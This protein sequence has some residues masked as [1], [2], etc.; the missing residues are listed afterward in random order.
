MY[1]I[2]NM[3]IRSGFVSNSSSSSFVILGKYVDIDNISFDTIKTNDIYVLGH[4]LNEGRDIF[5]IKNEEELAFFKAY[6]KLNYNSNYDFEF[7]NVVLF[8]DEDTNEIDLN[9]IPKVGKV[10]IISGDIDHNSS[11]D[12]NDIKD[13]YDQDGVIS[14]EIIKIIRAEKIDKIE[15]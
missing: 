10:N 11:N 5:K 6:Y 13:R 14:R 8:T 4:Y 15:K 2:I 3:K 9:E 7:I 1:Q 12:M